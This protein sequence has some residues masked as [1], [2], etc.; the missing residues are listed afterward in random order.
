MRRDEPAARGLG[1]R[2]EVLTGPTEAMEGQERGPLPVEAGMSWDRATIE[3]MERLA[4]Q[5]LGCPPRNAVRLVS[6]SAMNPNST[7]LTSFVLLCLLLGAVT[8]SAC[9]TRRGGGSS[10]DD[11]DSA[12]VDDDDDD[13]D[14]FVDDEVPMTEHCEPVSGWNDSWSV[15]EE[16]I[17]MLTNDVR[18][19]GTYCYPPNGSAEWYNPVGSLEMQE[20]LRCAARLHSVDMVER[21]FFDHTNPDGLGPGERM[22]DAGYP[23]MSFGE[24]IGWGY[25]TAEQMMVGWLESYGHCTNLMQ[26]FH[27]EIGVGY[28]AGAGQITWTQK[29]GSR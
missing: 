2:G 21:N 29:F 10:G 24:N 26:G 4:P 23:W 6:F 25:Q 5:A 13:D 16:M 7:R 9:T 27:T 11:D 12:A 15:M 17:V 8:L 28:F 20:N 3:H 1:Q 19:V 22:S 18:A 14:D